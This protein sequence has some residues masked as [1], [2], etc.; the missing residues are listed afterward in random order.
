VPLK[1]AF[2]PD[3]NA[4]PHP[5]LSP[6]GTV[7]PEYTTGGPAP[8]G[9]AEYGVFNQSGTLVPENLNTTTLVATF[10]GQ[11]AL[12]LEIGNCTPSV[13]A[14]DSGAPDAYG[15]QLNA[16]LENVTLF[17]TPGYEFWTQNVFEYS[18]YS[19]QLYVIT[20]IWNF[21][22]L[23][24]S[25]SSNAIASHGP[26]GTLVPG[27]LY[28]SVSG[29]YTIS[30]NYT[31]EI[32]LSSEVVGNNDTVVFE[33]DVANATLEYGGVN[34]YAIFNSTG[35][36]G[37]GVSAPAQYVA[38][39]SQYTPMGIPADW[40]FVMG[41]PGGG[42]NLDVFSM[43][44]EMD[45]YYW[46]TSLDTFAVIP[47]AYDV[48]SETG[49]TS[50]GATALWEG[51]WSLYLP[52]PGVDIVPGPTL[53]SGMWNVTNSTA[54]YVYLGWEVSPTNAF[55]FIAPQTTSVEDWQTFAWAPPDWIYFLPP[56][57][58]SVWS[59]ASNYDPYDYALPSLTNGSSF[60]NFV[61]LT[62][63]DYAGVYT[64]LWAL[65]QTGLENITW[66]GEI[67]F[68][69][70]YGQLGY[71]QDFGLYFPWFG[72]FNDY[73]YPVFAGILLWHVDFAQVISPPSLT[74]DYP[75]W[76]AGYLDYYG[77][78]K[79]NSLPMLFYDTYFTALEDASAITG[80]WFSAAE[81]GPT[82]PQYNVV[83]WNSS[84]SEII[85]NRFATG[86][87]ALYMY[88]GEDN[89]IMNNSFLQYIPNAPNPYALSGVYY[90]TYGLFDADF[91][92]FVFAGF[93]CDCWDLIYNNYFDTYFTAQS[94]YIDPYTGTPPI[95]PFS[96]EWNVSA[97]PGTNIIGGDYLGG[98]YWW[99]Y[100]ESENPYGVLPYGNLNFDY[101]F[102]WGL[103]PYGIYWGGDYLPLTPT[104][105]YTVTFIE[106]GLPTGTLW[107]PEVTA[108]DAGIVTNDT[109]GTF[110]NES[111]VA[112]DYPL[113]GYAFTSWF[114]YGG[115]TTLVV[116]G[117]ETVYVT[118]VPLYVVSFQ[119]TGLPGGTE[120]Y[121]YLDSI[122]S[123]YYNESNTTWVNFTVPAGD[124]D[125]GASAYAYFEA[126]NGSGFLTVT[127]NTTVTIAFLPVF[128]VTFDQSGLPSGVNW[129]ILIEWNATNGS[130][131]GS[132]ATSVSGPSV[133]LGYA[134]G[135]T[136]YFW[137][138][139]SPG[140][141]TTPASGSLTLESNT[142]LSVTFAASESLVFDESGLASG[143]AWTVSFTQGSTTTNQTSTE[144]SMTFAGVAG[145]YNYTVTAAGYVPTVGSGSGTLPV[146]GP[147]D[148]VFSPAPAT[149]V[150]DESGLAAGIHW[151]VN[152]TQNA[153]TTSYSGTGSIS[154]GAVYGAYSYTVNATGYGATPSSGAGVL[155][156]DTPVKIAF[157]LTPATM[158]FKET[159]L[160]SGTSWTVSFTQ[161][162]VTT[163][164]TGTGSISFD[165]VYGAYSY[166]VSSTGYGAIPASGSG[167]L[168]TDT[169]VTIAF[170]PTPAT[171]V[172]S[173][174]G[175]AAG[176]HWTVNFTQGGT[177]TAYSGTGSI[178][179]DAVYGAYSYTINATGYGPMP[180]SG[181][182]VL[183][184]DTP[185]KIAFALT[186]VTV[187]FEETGL[188]SGTS[189]TVSFTQD[190][191][192]TNY[193]GTGT[194]S[195]GAVYGPYTYTVTAA[196]YTGA[197]GSGS[198]P[199]DAS[200]TVS[201]AVHE[202]RLSGT[203]LPGS[204]TVT[205]GGSS[206]TLNAT[207]TYSEQ[208]AP[209][210]Y[211]VV[212]KASGYYPYYTNT[213]V[214]AGKTVYL[215]ASLQA[216]P[217]SPTPLLGVHGSSGWIVIALLALLAVAL[218][219]T[220]LLFWGR[221]RRPPQSSPSAW[222]ESAQTPAQGNEGGSQTPPPDRN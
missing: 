211:A 143:A 34:D 135:D 62:P 222:S 128:S 52:G 99:N 191:V 111:W 183:P 166:T 30:S 141:V 122:V 134:P 127:G 156:A 76:Y 60:V 144:T 74:V 142:T 159:G 83:F 100:G 25:M 26:N 4:N 171:I 68:N 66:N 196:N 120:W 46:N 214:F 152:F 37:P 114:T 33:F 5:S 204:A 7:Q 12:C 78:P 84:Y 221:S 212:V 73:T 118:F 195:I 54:G 218:L 64:P 10:T 176:T 209:G 208:L 105:V 2:L 9:I 126:P 174:T 21:S 124:Y 184:S 49:E 193:A 45:L 170:A 92:D 167:N 44:S 213:T 202:S 115:N 39:G 53:V 198:L 86:S 50:V 187:E 80:W 146:V 197:P 13:L 175:L 158:E 35:A 31:A 189:W 150:F 151:T 220:T 200:V 178:S 207:G 133:F 165:A 94:P 112:G 188:P 182:G 63:D 215:N 109:S 67:L 201:F 160:P 137:W 154:I 129:T 43:Y 82:A 56:G 123:S 14:M 79:T 102:I 132:F 18:T 27:E 42:S 88:G 138:V 97:T 58:Y 147:I 72:E 110:S 36:S 59:L 81:F 190:G 185:V 38:S 163:N 11:N 136:T 98:N 155:P 51:N 210:T 153:T 116:T 32:I 192:T 75:S 22:S 131:P 157:A 28:Y 85:G 41:G 121:V 130:G 91:G 20:N 23:G 87:S 96:E 194:I 69:N 48:G 172:F 205:V 89:L 119:E 113:D 125:Y 206:V 203:I 173:E 148:V 6:Y 106:S 57:N 140:Y 16:V 107:T 61:T 199:T 179:I 217:S 145:A 108:S 3:L 139:S 186:P 1:D 181:A 177:T 169:P 95:L 164:Y 65:N 8:I 29:P 216:V 101:Y 19:D 77:L 117:N 47:S 70:E 90:G 24:A 104:P 17:G 93:Y 55:T 103:D 180:A 168:P 149:V 161:G 219:C 15:L 40:E 71:D 162:G